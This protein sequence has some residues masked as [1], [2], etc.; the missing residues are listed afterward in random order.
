MQKTLYPGDGI[1]V[2]KIHYGTRFF[3]LKV[4]GI[5]PVK[6]N[7]IIVFNHP[8]ANSEI[9][10]KR[11]IGLPG[12]TLLIVNNTPYISGLLEKAKKPSSNVPIIYHLKFPKNLPQYF[13]SK[14]K[15]NY[16]PVIIPKRNMEIGISPINIRAYKTV[17]EKH[18]GNNIKIFNDHILINGKIASS[19][20]FKRN[21]YFT[22]G[23]NRWHS[24]DSRFWGF[25]PEED[26]IGKAILKVFSSRQNKNSSSVRFYDLFK[27]IY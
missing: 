25:L 4:P 22:L 17:I 12:D 13:R 23:D 20:R 24:T 11:C 1:V 16:G 18:E 26:I 7:D 6:R 9:W 19:Y 27:K 3:N 15:A 14:D 21:Y 5:S 2:S 8:Q 10:I